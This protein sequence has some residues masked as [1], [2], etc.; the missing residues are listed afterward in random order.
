MAEASVL[1]GV[2]I[3]AP[4]SAALEFRYSVSGVFDLVITIFSVGVFCVSVARY[5]LAFT[6]V[7]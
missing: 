2:R 6:A 7:A 5:A 1:L 3:D 4:I